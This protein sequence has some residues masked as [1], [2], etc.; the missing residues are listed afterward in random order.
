MAE[1]PPAA[2]PV[3]LKPPIAE[4]CG[5]S[6]E[7]LFAAVVTLAGEIGYSVSVCDTGRA[8]GTCNRVTRRIK[9]A[10]WLSPNGRLAAGDPRI[11][12]VRRRR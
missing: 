12:A 6:H 3:P 9:V 4:I 10:E 11:G 5:D 8:D 2:Q 7:S 1:L